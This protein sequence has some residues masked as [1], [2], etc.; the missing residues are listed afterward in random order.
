MLLK[1][2]Q[3]FKLVTFDCTNTLLYFKI[4]VHQ[5]YLKVAVEMGHK[6]EDFDET[7][8]FPSFKKHF[9][10]SKVKFPNFGRR[11]IG[12]E[13]WWSDLVQNV[14]SDAHRGNRKP[15][16]FENVADYLIKLYETQKC[17][18]KHDGCDEL[19]KSLK[20]HG[21]LVGIISNF[22]PRLHHLLRDMNLHSNFDFIITSYEANIEKPDRKIFELA[23][24]KSLGIKWDVIYP[25]ESLHIGNE[26]E[27]DYD[28]AINAGWSSVLIGSDA[29]GNKNRFKSLKEFYDRINT[30]EIEL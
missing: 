12:F 6:K 16:E 18:N 25:S 29:Q 24:D 4:P 7:K 28:G 11:S 27:T 2:L 17:W 22:D 15:E 19:I 23:L 26:V 5:Q 9:K 3:R 21:K 10:E 8:I 13:T 20:H 30:Q 14:L 1:N